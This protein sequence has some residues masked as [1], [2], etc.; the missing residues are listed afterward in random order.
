MN[1]N[2]PLLLAKKIEEA[3][4]KSKLKLLDDSIFI[5]VNADKSEFQFVKLKDIKWNDKYTL[6]EFI[7]NLSKSLQDK[8]VDLTKQ[9]NILQKE[10]AEMKEEISNLKKVEDE[11][12]LNIL[13]I[14]KEI[15][16]K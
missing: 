14:L 11:R 13:S 1:D 7:S 3:Q 10:N 6:D 16:K 9:M 8:K 15:N 5:C 4:K 2:N 12:Y